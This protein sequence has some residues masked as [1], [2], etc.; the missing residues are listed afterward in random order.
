MDGD[1][2]FQMNIQELETLR[3]L[4]LPIKCFVLNNNGYSSIMAM[5]ERYFGRLMGSEA[6]SGMTLADIVKVASSYG[7]TTYRIMDQ[8]NLMSEIENVLEMPGP[9]ICDVLIR[10]D[11]K[12]APSLSS[13]QKP[14]GSM[15]SKPLED[16]WPF[17][18]RSEFLSN[19][20]VPPIKED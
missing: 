16:L 11:E 8:S 20:I 17:L 15:I 13:V 14:D 4:N 5:Q 6:N 10:T 19:M 9:V 12:R 2:G 1:G 3:R 18:E 7:L